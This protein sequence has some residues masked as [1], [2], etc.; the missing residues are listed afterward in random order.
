MTD[1]VIV[2][3]DGTIADITHREHL[4]WPNVLPDGSYK[5]SG[6]HWDA[7]HAAAVHDSPH[8]KIIKLTNALFLGGLSIVLC[9]GRGDETRAKTQEWLDQHKVYWS[10]LHMRPFAD[11]RSD[12]VVKREMLARILADGYSPLFAIEDRPKVIEMWHK[13]GIR[14]IQVKQGD[15]V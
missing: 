8:E 11:Y 6:E 9:T 1:C 2:D 4:L 15:L 13:E 12:T 14:C 7:F 3:I 10:W 5:P